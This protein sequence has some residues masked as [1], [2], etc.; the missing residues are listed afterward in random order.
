MTEQLFPVCGGVFARSF[1]LFYGE[2]LTWFFTEVSEDGASVS[3]SCRT[4]E[5]RGEHIQGGSRYQR[6]CRM[7]QALDH[8]QEDSLK[9]MMAEYEELTKLV[10]EKFCIR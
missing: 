2:R 10:E 8:R 3:T 7:Q 4:M 5:N 9:Q 1:I 6:L